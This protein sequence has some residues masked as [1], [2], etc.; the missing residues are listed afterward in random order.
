MD[1]LGR[2]EESFHFGY[3]SML[4]VHDKPAEINALGRMAIAESAWFGFDSMAVQTLARTDGLV[5]VPYLRVMLDNPRPEIRTTALQGLCSALAR[6]GEPVEGPCPVWHASVDPYHVNSFGGSYSTPQGN[7]A[8]RSDAI[9]TWL[10]VHHPELS[11]LHAPAWYKTPAPAAPEEMAI[12]P[13]RHREPAFN[14]L[15]TRLTVQSGPAAVDLKLISTDMQTLGEITARI[16]ERLR[17]SNDAIKKANGAARLANKS[18]DPAAFCRQAAEVERILTDGLSEV[19]SRLSASGR[20]SLESYL[21]RWPV[22]EYAA[23]ARLG[24]W[25][26]VTG[27][28]RV[29]CESN[30]SH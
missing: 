9:K 17:A 8:E 19:E 18:P 22:H 2:T 3:A 24:K 11:Q 5:G 13:E 10:S 27:G 7:E 29:S 26:A 20:Q 15:L 14:I 23:S 1:A 12:S 28:S 30:Y 16:N 25:F 6:N 4:D 21:D